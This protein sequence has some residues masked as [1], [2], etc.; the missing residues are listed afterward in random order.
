MQKKILITGGLGYLW[1][2]TAAA[3][4]EAGFQVIL[5]DNLSNSHSEMLENLQSVCKQPITF[6]E[7]DIIDYETLDTIFEKEQEIWV[8]LHF[9]WKTKKKESCLEPFLYYTVN[10]QGTINILQLMEKYGIQNIIYASSS[11]VYDTEKGLSPFSENDK[12]K[13][14]TPFWN[15]K[16]IVEQILNDMTIQKKF[17]VFAVRYFNVIW[18]HPTHKLGF[19]PKGIPSKIVPLLLKVAKGEVESFPIFGGDYH[20]KD[21]TCLMDYIHVMDVADLHT[22]MVQFLLSKNNPLDESP[23]TP[24]YE[25]INVGTGYGRT[26]KEI[27]E[28]VELVTNT[29]ITYQIFEKRVGDSDVILGNA[30]KARKLF[31]REPKRTVIEAIEDAWGFEKY[32]WES[33]LNKNF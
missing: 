24:L 21:G 5:I 23:Q 1:I 32:Q 3:L 22:K 20:T 11:S 13:P 7:A 26:I 17:N 33:H 12:V 2:H 9:A 29:K 10:I 14:K 18:W 6:Y 16:L 25:I 31:Q 8:V 30:N 15:T 19:Y 27:I 4:S 28:M